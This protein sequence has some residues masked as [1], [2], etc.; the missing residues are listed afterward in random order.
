M[1]T[2]K[3]II[4]SG[5][6]L[7]CGSFIFS[8]T[9]KDDLYNPN[10]EETSEPKDPNS[11]FDFSTSRNI[12]LNINYG[13][14]DYSVLFEVYTSNPFKEDG[15]RSEAAAIYKAY[16]DNNG[17]FTGKV[18]V[19][20]F[21]GTLYIYSSNVGVSSL[22]P[23]DI[24]KTNTAEVDT[25]SSI[26]RANVEHTNACASIGANKG[27]VNSSKNIYSLYD[28]YNT[29]DATSNKKF[30]ANAW[31]PS[32]TKV[33]GIY[34]TT[35]VD[36]SLLKRINAALS[37]DDNTKY[38]AKEDHV[39]ITIAKKAQNG[40]D[41][42][43]A[44]IDLVLFHISGAYHNAVGYY[45]YPSDKPQSELTA[46]YIKSLPKFM[47]Y[48]RVTNW[49]NYNNNNYY[50]VPQSPLKARLQFFGEKYDQEG[51]DDFPAGY[52]IG[53]VLVPNLAGAYEHDYTL[54]INSPILKVNDQISNRIGNAIYSNSEAN[55]E[56]TK[57]FI[58]ASDKAT[59]K[60]IVGIEDGGNKD[61][62]DVLFT[63]ESDPIEAI[64]DPDQPVIPVDPPVVEDETYVSATGTYA[65]EDI[66][67]SGGDYDLN[68]VAVEYKT[69]VTINSNNIKKIEDTFKVITKPGAATQTNAFGYVINDSFGGTLSYSSP[70]SMTEDANQIIVFP[71]GN[72]VIGQE[73]TIK[74]T[75]AEGSYP[76]NTIYARN[77]N[78][79]IVANYVAGTKNRTEVH[80]PKA[81]ATSWADSNNGGE[82]AYYVNKEGK[83]PFAIDLQGATN[84]QLVSEKVKIG[85]SSEYPLFNNWVESKGLSHTD[86]YLYKNGK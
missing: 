37:S 33:S 57:R 70:S 30:G 69:T 13:I 54:N 40:N 81:K 5:V 58:T 71:N 51:T 9:S 32:N 53:W 38:I 3:L 41:V 83:Y 86:W 24:S 7:L 4:L 77:Y 19:P 39:N 34:S 46:N 74:R 66:W 76:N 59:G 35:E 68:D 22:E 18:Q 48:P 29:S 16:T 72:S 27:I 56:Q 1:K 15:T 25:R 6:L 82:N 84:F 85:E 67:P 63:V 28:T 62:K 31:I 36:G 45:Y 75:F 65:F 60:V 47:V 10:Q 8:C 79:F 21:T 78:P 49:P 14:K 12:S 17:S 55:S 20:A 52:T 2:K 11:I 43:D 42:K 61:M 26:T 73:F 23:I 50:N 44:H 64:F 80:L